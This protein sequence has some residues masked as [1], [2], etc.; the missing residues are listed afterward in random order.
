MKFSKKQSILV[1][2]ALV[3][4]N[5]TASAQ[6][7]YILDTK[8]SFS[9][10]GTSTL[11][12]WEMTSASKNGNA[13]LTVTDSKVVDINSINI[14]LAV[15]TIKSGKSG[16]DKIAYETL[17]IKKFK[18]IKYVLKSASK[19]NETTWNLTG[20]YTIAGVSKD[21][22]TQI[23][24]AVVNGVVNIQGANKITFD[25]F[26]M[27]APTALLGTIKTGKDLTIKF[28]LNYK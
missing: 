14:D 23:K 11:H 20:T 28:N 9:V 1:L 16:M 6:K 21:L 5:I 10:F 25:E 27:K 4:I 18:T 8:T 13:N 2:F 19:V 3:F 22:K 7:N 17:N 12:D 24:V 26:G 15:E